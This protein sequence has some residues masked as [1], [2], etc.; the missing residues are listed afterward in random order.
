MNIWIVAWA[1]ATIALTVAAGTQDMSHDGK[2]RYE[3]Y[4]FPGET[5]V[6]FVRR[7]VAE[8]LW[9]QSMPQKARRLVQR[10]L[11][12]AVVAVV[13]T[14][15]ALAVAHFMG[16]AIG[17]IAVAVLTF[18]FIIFFPVSLISGI[19]ASMDHASLNGWRR[20]HRYP[21]VLLTDKRTGTNP[22]MKRRQAE[23]DAKRKALEEKQRKEA[24][25]KAKKEEE[26]RRRQEFL[27]EQRLERERI[28]AMDPIDVLD[29]KYHF[30]KAEPGQPEFHGYKLVYDYE[31]IGGSLFS[32]RDSL[33]TRFDDAYRKGKMFGTPGG[34]LTNGHFRETGSAGISGEQTFARMIAWAD[35]PIV[36][37]WSLSGYDKDGKDIEADI[38]C[39]LLGIDHDKNLYAWFIDV[40]NYSGGWGTIYKNLDETHLIRFTRGNHVLL[41][42]PN[43][44]PDL[45]MSWNMAIQQDNWT[46][47]LKRKVSPY[48][49]NMYADCLVTPAHGDHGAPEFYLVRWPGDIR[50]ESA[51]NLIRQIS[52][53]DL[54]HP[55]NIPFEVIDFFK[56][57]TKSAKREWVQPKSDLYDET[58]AET[59]QGHHTRRSESSR[60]WWSKDCANA[61]GDI[62]PK[63]LDECSQTLEEL[64]ARVD[65]LPDLFQDPNVGPE[66]SRA[67]FQEAV[68]KT[69]E[70]TDILHEHPG[71]FR[72]DT[73]VDDR[74]FMAFDQS[75]KDEAYPYP[76]IPVR[77]LGEDHGD[78]WMVYQDP[79]YEYLPADSP[80]V[81]ALMA[82]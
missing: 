4:M 80:V 30:E 17:I 44:H 26:E 28:A 5:D 64:G 37:F 21:D 8:R 33:T 19:E 12:F 7:Q 60:K 15:I 25:V 29:E 32:Y 11:L 75:R 51:E 42:G 22:E 46:E 76:L 6:E 3:E 27:E 67:Y 38:D 45:P 81:A 59:E 35:L 43:G 20:H 72:C 54:S 71:I 49:N 57:K 18:A 79:F 61:F 78:G 1:A 40:K 13:V 24:E 62:D 69:G 68:E 47:P 55:S 52:V 34:G 56:K 23:L 66:D 31:E 53:L 74:H 16:D 2:Y 82:D 63:E 65:V 48:V 41:A 36:S 58:L 39:V 50:T 9:T 77:K 70:I 73:V 10:F 14:L